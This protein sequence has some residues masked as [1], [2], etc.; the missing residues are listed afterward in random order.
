VRRDLAAQWAEPALPRIAQLLESDDKQVR[1]EA[2][3]LLLAI[4]SKDLK[5]LPADAD[6]AARRE[7]ARRAGSA[8]FPPI[9]P[10]SAGLL[11]LLPSAE[12]E[13]LFAA[14]RQALDDSSIG[15][16]VTA[17][18]SADHRFRGLRIDRVPKELEVLRIPLGA[19]VTAIN[20]TP[21]VDVA[22]V[23]KALA[24]AFETRDRQGETHQL[25]AG[26]VVVDYMFEGKPRAM[27]YRVE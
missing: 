17:T 15:E 18:D 16:T 23:K 9:R 2:A 13:A 1:D 12:R 21:V 22:Q 7:F 8:M 27:E 3:G 10:L 25:S 6:A 4:G 26:R 5:P 19:V 20:G 24:G 11:L 14:G